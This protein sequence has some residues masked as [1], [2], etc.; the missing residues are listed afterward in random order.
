MSGIVVET[1]ALTKR[2]GTRTAVDAIDLRV[3]AGSV[4]GLVGPNGAGKTT[5]FSLLLGYVHP[6]SGS[7]TILGTPIEHP[8]R[9]KGRVGALPQDA[10][11]PEMAAVGQL[12]RYYGEL[13]GLSANDAARETRT[14]LELFGLIDRIDSRV[15]ALSHGM[16][17][18][19]AMAQAF[20]GSPELV[21]LDEPT[22]GLDPRTAAE[23]RQYLRTS[24]RGRTIVISSH[25]LYELED[26][27][28]HVGILREGKLAFAGT[29][30]E[31]KGAGREVVLQVDGQ[32]PQT[33]GEALQAR[34][35]EVYWE[36]AER[37]VRIVIRD[38]Q[39]AE[40]AMS[41]G[42][43]ALAQAGVA[44]TNVS[45]GRSLEERFLELTAPTGR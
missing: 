35:W 41:D 44:V 28:T 13:G 40:T 24:Q 36:P 18:R 3:P 20:L 1:H 31:I 14:V 6:T 9:R 30:G 12:L 42:L 19:V 7:G 21:V 8:E 10:R 11:L 34:G 15:R 37:R 17:K 39:N 2:Y 25:V 23:V 43:A 26:L 33:V 22:S 45:R 32:V 27:C 29:I 5:T 4:Y 38:G 16:A